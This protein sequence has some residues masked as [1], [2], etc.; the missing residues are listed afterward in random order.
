ME[1]YFP[2]DGTLKAGAHV[3]TVFSEGF[4]D[5]L[6]KFSEAAQKLTPEKRDAYMKNL[7]WEQQ[8]A[9]DAE[10]WPNK[11]DYNK[12]IEEWRKV[13]IQAITPVAVGLQ[14][15]GDNVWRVLSIMQ[16][17]KTKQQQPL[18]ISALRY[19]A[20]RNVWISNN[21]EMTARDYSTPETSLYGA[22]TGTEWTVEKEDALTHF[23]ETIRVSKTTDGK[24]IYLAYSFVEQSVVTGANVAQGAYL[25]QF[26]VQTPGANLGKPGQR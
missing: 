12:F 25:L 2:T 24:N 21:G 9:Y 5:Q 26:P 6:Q 11:E 3:R 20:N 10:I 15:V 22:Q 19:D 8:P 4:R 14:S 23:R 17:V 13:Q 16:D 7:S 18:T 1:G